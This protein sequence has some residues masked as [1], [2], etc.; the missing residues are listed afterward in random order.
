MMKSEM[1]MIKYTCPKCGS[2]RY[3]L[4]EIRVAYSLLTQIFN[5]QGAKYSAIICEKCSYTELYNVPVKK[6]TSVF[7]FFVG[8]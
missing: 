5:I 8:S 3:R 4:N 2:R 1:P 7:D 6:I